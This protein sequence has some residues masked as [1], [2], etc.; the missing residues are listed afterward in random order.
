MFNSSV[1]WGGGEKWHLETALKMKDKGLK[2]VLFCNRKGLLYQKAQS[3]NI[4]CVPVSIKNLSFLNPFKLLYLFIQ[5]RKFRPDTIIVGLTSDLKA[6]AMVAHSSGA[7]NLIYRRGT[8]LPLKNNLLNSWLYSRLVDAIIVNSREIQN[9]LLSQNAHFIDKNKIH[10]IYNE[11]DIKRI[12]K[13]SG[14]Q[15]LH[16]SDGKIV[17]GNIGRLVEQK[18]QDYLIELARRL[19]KNEI[20]FKILIAGS[21]KLEGYLKTYARK[22]DVEEEIVFMNFIEDINAFIHSI[23]IFVFPSLHEGSSHTL[24]EVMAAKKPVVAFNISSMPEIIEHNRN[25]FLVDKGDTEN[26]FKYVY[27]L[28]KREDLR[29]AFGENGR[30]K[31]EHQFNSNRGFSQ[32]FQLITRLNHNQ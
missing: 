25:G 27:E 3:T 10:L 12:D 23:D 19:K 16:H 4:E 32:L 31:V 17:L 21:G 6:T 24:L 26:L 15:P 1:I 11:M 13:I 5:L 29:K 9:I 30:K 22:L 7:R 2:P 18:G 28:I 14:Q 20:P 8:A